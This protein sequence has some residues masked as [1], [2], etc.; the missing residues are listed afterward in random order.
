M[1][2]SNAS[3]T[4]AAGPQQGGAIVSVRTRAE[5]RDG[6]ATT[7]APSLSALPA[8]VRLLIEYVSIESLQAYKN[9]PRTHSERQIEQ[10][11]ASVA[12]FG[13][14]QPILI[15]KDSEII[16]GHGLLA[17]ARSLGYREV[18]IV[19]LSHLSEPDKRALRLGLNRLAELAGW[20]EELLALE[21]KVLLEYDLTLDL[22]FDLAV[23]GFE[24]PV[25]DQTVERSREQAEAAL[26]DALPEIDEA[27]PPV[28]RLNDVFELSSH[29]IICGDARDAAVHAKLLGGQRAAMGIHDSPYNV[30]VNG[31]VSKSGR[32]SEFVMAS[33]EMS[34]PEFVRFL[35]SFLVQAKASSA[36]GAVQFAFMDWRHNGEMLAAG[37][38]AGLTLKNL[39]IWNKGVGGLGGLYRSA[40]EEVFVF[41]DP[42]GPV[43]N[44][45]QLGKFGRNRTN[46]WDFPGVVSMRKELKSHPTPKSV[47]MIAE[48]IR[49]CSDR[50]EIV[51]DCFSGSGTSIIA[52][53]KTGRLA[54][55]IDLDPH[56]VDVAVKRWEAWSGEQ[57]R[58]AATGLT[59]AEL[60]AHRAAER[61]F[62]PSPDTALAAPSDVSSA[63]VARVRRRPNVA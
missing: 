55:V 19:R 61:E 51:L 62:P 54:R 35:T 16:G 8:K 58:H 33:G 25:I 22:S 18:P 23:T 59:F 30:A 53:A 63:P 6:A 34:E 17:A 28:S 10:L 1:P 39:C 60:A 11:A 15:D 44:N 42:N 29:R 38:A 50:N 31:H 14:C 9:N 20:S 27:E 3:L 43:K 47:S 45:V 48:A 57:A 46:V 52:A 32:H 26:D 13:F 40:H 36:P 37:K 49:D 41:A 56:Y 5:A 2:D 7:A 12:A 4:V 24:H 21:F